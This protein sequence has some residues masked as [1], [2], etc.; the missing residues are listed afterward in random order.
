MSENRPVLNIT[1][2]EACN[3]WIIFVTPKFIENAGDMAFIADEITLGNVISDLAY[4]RHPQSGEQLEWPYVGESS[5][6][7]NI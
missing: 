6:R 4:N 5:I 7:E 1:I 3:G 2:N